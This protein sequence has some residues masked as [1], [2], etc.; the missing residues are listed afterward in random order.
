MAV[1]SGERERGEDSTAEVTVVKPADPGKAVR[2]DFAETAFFLPHLLTG[3]DGSAAIEFTP[4][5]SVTEWNVWAHAI[6]KDV[7]SGS[8]SM[9]AKTSKDL[10]VR[11]YVPRFFRE[12]D[13]AE[14]RVVLTNG[15]DKELK[16][17]LPLDLF[18]P[19][20]QKSVSGDWALK[21]SKKAFTLPP[22]GSQT[23][24][25]KVTTP[26]KVGEVAFKAVG[27]A[28]SWTDGEV[29]V[30][31]VLPSRLHLSQSRFVVS[32]GA[33]EKAITFEELLA[34]TDKSLQSEQLVVTVD[35][36]LFEAVLAALP[37]LLE[38]PYECTEQTLNRFLSAGIVS[39]VMK[40][41]PDVAKR[42]AAHA[43]R[44]TP[45][46]QFNRPD[47]NRKAQ[48]EET[49]WLI[50]AKG[51]EAPASAKVLRVLDPKVANASRDAALQKLQEMQNHDG[52]FPWFPG[53]PSSLYMT[54]YLL[55]GFSRGVEYGVALPKS[56]VQRAWYYV[57]QQLRDDK[58]RSTFWTDDT[59]PAAWLTFLAYVWTAYPD[60]TWTGGAVTDADLKLVIDRSFAKWR[61]LSP[62]MK[63][64]L[65]VTLARRDRVADGRKVFESVM[66]SAKSDERLGVYWAPEDKSWLWYRDSIETHAM[67]L[68]T[69]S[70]LSPKDER[71]GG[72]VQ[73]LFLNKKLNQ[74]KST[75]ATAE[76]IYALVKYLDAE[77]QLSVAETPK[78]SV[79][80]PSKSFAFEPERGQLRAQWVVP[81]ELLQPPTKISVSKPTPGTVFTS[82]T[83]HFATDLLPKKGDGDLLLV[84]RAYAK[85]IV[86]GTGVRLEPLKEGA[87]VSL[88][89]ELEVE[90]KVK[91]LHAAEYVHVRDPRGAGFEP[92]S[93]TSA[94]KWEGGLG[95]FE[96]VRDTGTNFFFEQ[97]PA[98]EY[99]LRYRLRATM[100]G[101][102]RVGPAFAQSMYAPEFTAY[103]SGAV[104]KVR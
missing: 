49:P 18:D 39:A 36:Q 52:G 20:T 81:G 11:P 63:G 26:R 8:V 9:R 102:F 24:S 14:L 34:S 23:L 10:L 6:T 68:Q 66:D 89:E 17:E 3:P 16:G 87:E 80:T 96:E 45:L 59:A 65:A 54:L 69:L 28:G 27:T 104:M 55:N 25:F 7:R 98:G 29:R 95:F 71:R 1:E 56:M 91:A 85:R 90:L 46:E 30:L 42:M 43:G 19:A 88:G 53:G 103:S 75:R 50:E 83:W 70:A 94:F 22:K 40:K 67:A 51:G 37:Y 33:G 76:V 47:A 48:L 64:M 78:V 101:T 2:T 93:Q 38:Y 92:V 44:S 74:W 84:S 79:V 15:A 61:E 72:L 73:W 21:E 57:G 5:D 99:T 4:P 12:G 62:Y 41:Y 82:A 60:A 86:E 35:A 97:L 100:S 13:A 32:R 77:G 58:R 31:P